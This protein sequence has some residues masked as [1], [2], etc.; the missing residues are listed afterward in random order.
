M[1]FIHTADWQIG[2]VFRNFGE[3]ESVLRQARLKV[4]EKIG[5]VALS[6]NAAIVLI[7]GDLYDTEAP[8]PKTMREPIERMKRFP[9]VAW[10]VIPGNHDPHRPNGLWDRLRQEGLPANLHVHVAPEPVALGD[11]AVLLPAPLR[12]KSEV[13]DLTSWM[14]GAATADGHI[15][16]GLAHGSVTGF[17]GDGEASNPVAPDRA[18]RAGLSYLALGDWH[19][20]REIN[21]STWY[22]G[23]PEPDRFGS[24]ETG[25]VLLVE[26]AGAGVPA[27]V[28]SVATGSHRWLSL[29]EDVSGDGAIADLDRKIR[30]LPELSST[31]LRLL[32]TGTLP[33]AARAEIDRRVEA[34]SAALCHL[35]CSFD[36]L[37][38][39]PSDADLGAIDFGGV[40]R[41]AA[42]TLKAR[43]EDM[44]EA[45]EKRR[46]AADALVRLFVMATAKP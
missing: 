21:P 5:E 13:G 6:E 38:A 32:L 17:G 24:Q 8:S 10:H 31:I 46:R 11:D 22:A 40:L 35:D 15:R 28:T 45:P 41:E 7:A 26:I 27:K 18:R 44:A 20:T 16:I 39:Q 23:T 12:R 4:I 1:R 29:T 43:A 25:Q 3:Q 42:E 33:L 36:G 14:D 37:V 30:A 9:G 19:R 2:K 34:L